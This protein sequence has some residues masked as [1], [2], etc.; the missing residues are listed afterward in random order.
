MAT[1][2]C[3]ING[4][5]AR[6]RDGNGVGNGPYWLA[7]GSDYSTTMSD[8]ST[9]GTLNGTDFVINPIIS[10]PVINGSTS[11]SNN[12]FTICIKITTPKL[13]NIT[14][15]KISI[16]CNIF[17]HG[18][19][20]GTVYAS[21]RS[22]LTSTSSDTLDT[23]RTNAIGSEASVS[24]VVAS[25]NSPASVT[26]EFSSTS[27]KSNTAYYLFLY[28]KNTSH[29]YA[30]Y[31]DYDVCT[32]AEITYVTNGATLIWNDSTWKKCRPLVWDGSTWRECKM[33]IWNGSTWKECG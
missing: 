10:S 32:G 6:C 31:G 16:T 2:N 19:T 7:S 3:T 8:L 13:S 24:N 21:L 26:F 9:W 12:K 5:R 22:S 1:Q 29:I 15:S 25:V 18:S 14:I 4:M 33:L 30:A 23:Y 11:S 28:T 17:R 20:T 27:L